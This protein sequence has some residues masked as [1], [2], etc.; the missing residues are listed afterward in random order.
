MI[1]ARKLKILM[2]SYDWN[3]LKLVNLNADRKRQWFEKLTDINEKKMID[4]MPWS[5]SF[6]DKDSL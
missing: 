2:I 4:S 1:F 6:Y 3:R 5:L